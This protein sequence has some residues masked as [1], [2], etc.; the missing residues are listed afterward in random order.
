VTSQEWVDIIAAVDDWFPKANWHPEHAVNWFTDLEQFDAVDVWTGLLALKET[1]VA[2]DGAALIRAATDA[3][4][5]GKKPSLLQAMTRRRF[6][7]ILS[8]EDTII[9]IHLERPPCGNKTCDLHYPKV[10]A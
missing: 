3:A 6:G 2:P 7:E 5:T 10:D 8:V 4:D 9:R 1:D